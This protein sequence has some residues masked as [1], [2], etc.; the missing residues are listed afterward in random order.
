MEKKKENKMSEE[1][2]E[3]RIMDENELEAKI[4][5]AKSTKNVGIGILALSAGLVVPL[6]IKGFSG[7]WPETKE[8]KSFWNL[9]F[10]FGGLSSAVALMIGGFAY[11]YGRSAIDYYQNMRNNSDVQLNLF[12]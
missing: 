12:K 11:G 7:T 2:N 6:I 4:K 10:A 1:L 8:L 3:S 5:D 9:Y